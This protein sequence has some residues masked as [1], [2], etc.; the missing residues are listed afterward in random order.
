MLDSKGKQKEGDDVTKPNPTQFKAGSPTNAGVTLNDKG[1]AV[2]A[3]AQPLNISSSAVPA[4]QFYNPY[5]M[6]MAGGIGNFPNGMKRGGRILKHGGSIRK[7]EDGDY[8]S[9][10]EMYDIMNTFKD[11]RNHQGRY[12][13]ISEQIAGL[14]DGSGNYKGYDEFE[15]RYDDEKG[16]YHR[17]KINNYRHYEDIIQDYV[18]NASDS[19]IEEMRKRYGFDY[20]RRPGVKPPVE[21]KYDKNGVPLATSDTKY[22]SVPTGRKDEYELVSRT[23]TPA[24]TTSTQASPVAE[25]STSEEYNYPDRGT[26]NQI[27]SQL[28]KKKGEV[29]STKP[30]FWSKAS[31]FLGGAADGLSKWAELSPAL[32]KMRANPES[33]S[34]DIPDYIAGKFTHS[35]HNALNMSAESSASANAAFDRTSSSA[36]ARAAYYQVNAN[37]RSNRDSEIW[38]DHYNKKQDF[39]NRE[40]DRRTQYNA[41]VSGIK[42]QEADVNMKNRA[43]AESTRLSGYQ[44]L[45]NWLQA[46]R[47]EMYQRKRDEEKMDLIK[48]HSK[49]GMDDATAK[50]LGWRK[51]GGLIFKDGGP[52]VRP[53]LMSTLMPTNVSKQPTER[54]R[55]AKNGGQIPKH[56]LG[57]LIGGIMGKG[58]SGGGGIGGLFGGS[59][60]NKAANIIGAAGNMAGGIKGMINSGN[61][62]QKQQPQQQLQ[63]PQQQISP[64]NVPNLQRMANNANSG[65]QSRRYGGPIPTLRGSDSKANK[66]AELERDELAMNTMGQVFRVGGKTHEKGGEKFGPDVLPPGSIVISDHLKFPGTK[67]TYAD[68]TQQAIQ[69]GVNPQQ[70]VPQMFEMQERNKPN[71]TRNNYG[72]NGLRIKH[73]DGTEGP[74]KVSIPTPSQISEITPEARRDNTRTRLS[75]PQGLVNEGDRYTEA[76]SFFSDT[77]NGLANMNPIERGNLALESIIS[78]YGAFKDVTKGN[79]GMAAIS[80]IPG[81]GLIR[82]AKAAGRAAKVSRLAKETRAALA[83][84]KSVTRAGKI[85]DAAEIARNVD[86]ATPEELLRV[87]KY[88]S[89]TGGDEINT[90]RRVGKK[91]DD[92]PASLAKNERVA[93]RQ[94]KED[95]TNATKK[96]KNAAGVE[97]NRYTAKVGETDAKLKDFEESYRKRSGLKLE[98][99][100]DISKM[101][102]TDNS[103]YTRLFNAAERAKQEEAAIGELSAISEKLKK[104]KIHNSRTY[105]IPKTAKNA[106]IIGGAGLGAILGYQALG[107]I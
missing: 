92:I 91:A 30:G 82:A 70:I 105:Q 106:A 31:N 48:A 53:S 57:N 2:P 18:D 45:S 16:K 86:K 89:A 14:K 49:L 13:S 103:E 63:Q 29:K 68:V 41:M 34:A 100:I 98:D 12:G 26:Y 99:E 87:K 39:Y 36:G 11:S 38:D 58:G 72:R 28:A 60:G 15:Y 78:P 77:I 76:P 25:Q 44:D 83:S 20:K 21:S 56:F 54:R 6:S 42:N 8:I 84:G 101:D 71:K 9:D 97:S 1:A 24:A 55:Y 94:L 32:R 50:E 51:H 52:L 37:H 102:I 4:N 61:N 75:P 74:N 3:N 67:K 33:F 95:V 59:S 46:G 69:R 81:I 17:K 62:A 73:Y 23:P 90:I 22:R 47:Q 35:P 104:R 7:H 64:G 96:S 66:I 65:L 107:Q 88:H 27:M 40:A 43:A 10:E 79:Y 80:L 5:G 19:E 85:A 93:A